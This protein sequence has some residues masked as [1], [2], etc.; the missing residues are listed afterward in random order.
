MPV[1]LPLVVK[2]VAVTLGNESL[3]IVNVFP[4]CTAIFGNV[5]ESVDVDLSPAIHVLRLADDLHQLFVQ[6]S[7]LL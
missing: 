6:R 2:L 4:A 7:V 1:A 5:V 3:K